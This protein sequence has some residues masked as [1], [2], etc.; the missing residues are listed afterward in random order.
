MQRGHHVAFGGPVMVMQACIGQGAEQGADS[1]CNTERFT[2]GDDVTQAS[3]NPVQAMRGIGQHLQGDIGH[4]QPLDA[5]LVHCVEQTRRITPDG[6]V[7]QY[8][9]APGCQGRMQFLKMHIEGHR[10]EGQGA[11]GHAKAWMVNVPVDQMG[12]R[13]ARHGD[14]LGRTG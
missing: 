10:R 8:Q 6:I 2:G 9:R 7:D 4:E 1:W 13:R 5:M 3:R 12:E 14:T 11:C